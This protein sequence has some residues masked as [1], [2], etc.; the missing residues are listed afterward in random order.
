MEA[1]RD[2]ISV[3]TC[4]RWYF[5]GVELPDLAECIDTDLSFQPAPK[6]SPCA[7]WQP[8]HD[9]GLERV[10]PM[11]SSPEPIREKRIISFIIRICETLKRYLL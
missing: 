9:F 4:R 6:R 7:A 2:E 10:R 5:D 8:F 1:V 3:D 11:S